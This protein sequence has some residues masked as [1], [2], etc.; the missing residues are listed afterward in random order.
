M[1]KYRTFDIDLVIIKVYYIQDEENIEII[2][3]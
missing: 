1:S 3:S 2:S